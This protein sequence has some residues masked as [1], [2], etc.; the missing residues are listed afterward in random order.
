MID[1]N[2]EE[3]KAIFGENFEDEEDED[4]DTVNMMLMIKDKFA[5]CVL[6]LARIVIYSCILAKHGHQ[7]QNQH[8]RFAQD[9][10]NDLRPYTL[11]HKGRYAPGKLRYLA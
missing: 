3:V 11:A 1:M 2:V 8:L 9:R 10:S 5:L 6:V 4:F 7:I